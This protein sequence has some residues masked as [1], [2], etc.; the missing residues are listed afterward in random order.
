MQALSV[1][2]VRAV[3]RAR[4]EVGGRRVPSIEKEP[5]G[6]WRARYRDLNGQS[7]S[8]TFEKRAQAQRFLDA[9]KAD[10]ARG[11][12]VDPI[13]RRTRFDEWAA[14][15]E[16][17]LVRVA[18]TTARRYRQVL[19]AHVLPYFSDRAIASI[20]YADVEGFI[21]SEFKRG[22][23]AKS[24]RHSVS[25]LA[26]VLRGAVWARVL[27]ENPASDHDISVRRQA[28]QA[29]PISDLLRVAEHAREPYRAAVLL[30]VYTGM[31]PAPRTTWPPRARPPRPRAGRPRGT[32]RGLPA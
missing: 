7:R 10:M 21:A 23:A 8:Q 6:H 26:L 4:A 14:L 2:W 18:P 3:A 29:L 22:L 1:S 20:D 28:G 27:R 30:L 5:S 19:H 11:D 24:V 15:W 13:G 17:G 9:T 31:R 16:D 32:P 12:W 25:V